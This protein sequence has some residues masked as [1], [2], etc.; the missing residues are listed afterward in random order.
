M[1]QT[2]SL[3]TD[4]CQQTGNVNPVRIGGIQKQSLIDYPGKI[5]CVLF[6]TGC[7]LQCP[8]CHNPALA[9]GEVADPSAPAVGEFLDFLHRRRGFLDGVVISGGEPTI[10]SGLASLCEKIRALGYPIKLDTNGS[11]PGIV[12]R[13]IADDLVNYVAMDIKTH[14]LLYRHHLGSRCDPAAFLDSI[15]LIVD[16][17]VDHEFRTTCVRPIVSSGIVDAIARLIHDADRYVL[18]RF[19][20][21]DVLRPDFF[22]DDRARPHTRVELE[23][24]SQIAARHVACCAVR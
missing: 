3:N 4:L 12:A 13:L 8:Y 15:R 10:H 14:P 5:S 9:R 2:A 21:T 24:L 16:S 22:Q 23:R 11:R 6:L 17:G 7:N 18:Q 19:S 20:K 1:I